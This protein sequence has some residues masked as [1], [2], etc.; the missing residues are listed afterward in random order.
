MNQMIKTPAALI[1]KAASKH[2]YYKSR[3][4]V[5]RERV[6]HASCEL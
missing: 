2:T 1:T 5:D 4:L 6:E 3:F